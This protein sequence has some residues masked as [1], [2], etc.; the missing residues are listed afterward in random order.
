M[1]PLVALNTSVYEAGAQQGG[2]A[3]GGDATMGG[4]NCNV[5]YACTVTQAPKGGWSYRW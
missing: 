3:T 2:A 4:L 5:A 1:T